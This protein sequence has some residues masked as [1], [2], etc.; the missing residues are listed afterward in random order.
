MQNLF[1]VRRSCRKKGGYRQIH[2][3]KG[4]LQRYIFFTVVF[5]TVLHVTKKIVE[6]KIIE[7]SHKFLLFC[8]AYVYGYVL[9]HIYKDIQPLTFY[10]SAEAKYFSTFIFYF[11]GEVL[12][13]SA[14]H[15]F[16]FLQ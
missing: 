9:L 8:V 11:L 3:H 16:F 5:Y 2:T 1:A 12:F 4:T 10:F 7:S 13:S 15:V 6:K 14:N